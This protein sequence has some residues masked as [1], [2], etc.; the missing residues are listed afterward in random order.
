MRMLEKNWSINEKHEKFVTTPDCCFGFYYC[1]ADER[2]SVGAVGKKGASELIGERVNRGGFVFPFFSSFFFLFF[3]FL[4]YV[5]W[6]Y[7]Q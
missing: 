3:L 4:F 2:E 5:K 6:K 7:F 1:V